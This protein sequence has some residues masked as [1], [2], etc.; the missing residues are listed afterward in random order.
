[1]SEDHPPNPGAM[2][3]LIFTPENRD[4]LN[5]EHPSLKVGDDGGIVKLTGKLR[6]DM[7]FDKETDQFIIFPKK[8][9]GKGIRIQDEYEVEI[10]L[11]KSRV[12]DLPQVFETDSRIRT[13]AEDKKLPLA[14]FH[15]NGDGSV[16]LCVAGKE[17]EYFPDGFDIQIFFNQL[18]V[19]FFY[20]QTY[21]QKFGAW[22][23]GEYGHGVL[24][25]FEWYNEKQSL[26]K[27]EVEQM[28]QTFKSAPDWPLIVTKFKGSYKIKGH[29]DCICGKNMKIRKCHPLAFEG[30]WKFKNDLTKFSLEYELFA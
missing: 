13:L 25:I 29:M 30:M 16:C 1:M 2:L 24:G 17:R 3:D 12:S 8:Y 23:W 28:I 5:R 21:V 9:L 14:D 7:V 27:S 19:P 22:P 4:W 6:F 15:L 10:L 26:T 18:V 11:L 20:A